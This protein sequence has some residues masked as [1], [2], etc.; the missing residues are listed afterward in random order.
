MYYTVIKHS[1]HS[2]TLKKCRKH[3]P[4]VG[5]FYISF[6]FSNARCLLSQ[7][8]TWLRLLYLLNKS[9]ENLKDHSNAVAHSVDSDIFYP[10]IHL[11]ASSKT[12]INLYFVFILSRVKSCGVT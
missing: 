10:V 8:N 2:R 6:V 3:S 9:V 4:G 5:V 12:C 1:G 11:P 7:C